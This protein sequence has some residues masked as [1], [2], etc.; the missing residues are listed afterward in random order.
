MSEAK[1]KVRVKVKKKPTKKTD[2]EKTKKDI[3]IYGLLILASIAILFILFLL[4]DRVTGSE[5]RF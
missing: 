2:W 4:I 5:T 3:L 1:T